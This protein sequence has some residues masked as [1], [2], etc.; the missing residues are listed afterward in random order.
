MEDDHAS[1]SGAVVNSPTAKSPY[2]SPSE[3]GIIVPVVYPTQGEGMR[4]EDGHHPACD[5]GR[6]EPP[7]CTV[8]DSEESAAPSTT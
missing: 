5:V 6:W 8:P 3:S 4:A 1:G 7:D 2:P